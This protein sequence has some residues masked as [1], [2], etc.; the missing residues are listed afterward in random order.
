[1]PTAVTRRR[2]M[3]QTLG[4]IGGTMV[5]GPLLPLLAEAAKRKQVL[6][7][8]VE[9]DFESLRPDMSAGY[10]NFMLK[11]LI[12]TTALLWGTK[13]R[14]DGTLT[15]DLN[16]IEPLL[17]TAYKVSDDR[18]LIEFTLR[19]NAKF[20]NGDPLHAP[21]LKEAYAWLFA[22]GG[23]GGNQLKV[24]GVPNAEHIEAVDDVTLRL[25]LDRPVAWGLYGNALLGTSI[26]H[27]KEIMKHATA[28]DPYGLKWLETKTIASGPFVI[29]TW[30]K[31]SMMSLVPNPHAVQPSTLER[32]ILQVVPDA[33]TRRI[34]LE[35]GDVDFAMQISTKDIPD[36]RKASGVKVTSYPSSR[37]WWFGMTWRKEPFNNMHFR[38]AMAW[39]MPYE[40]LL[41]VVTQGLAERLRS[42]VPNNI[43]GYVEELWPYETNL[44]KAREELAQVQ[45]PEGFTMTVP[46]SAGDLFDEEA[47]VLIKE[48][49]AKLGITLSIQKMPTGQKRT[50][51]T[52]KQVDMAVYDW[53]PWTPDAGYFIHWNWLPDSFWNCWSYVNPEAQTLGYETITM[54][55]GAPERQAKLRRFQEIVNGDIGL[56]PLVSEFENVVTRENVQG[57]VS[58]PDGIPVLAK[59]SLE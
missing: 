50:L 18:Q 53:R 40:T 55:T 2:F 34:V 6:R 19:P 41:Q 25:H 33:S 43:S 24:N 20:A 31:G 1:M 4:V 10:T 35:R 39:A 54:A 3:G 9:R 37:G 21:A 17:L 42:C 45:V 56:I 48:S 7:V 49:L 22:N 52:N 15:Y 57:Y 51:L 38:R 26:V 46:V 47:T 5:S 29:E 30:Q 59:L 44:E 16:T 23:S 32:I 14:P 58:Y 13:Q 27:A 12:Y 28:D 11:R 36:L 8:A